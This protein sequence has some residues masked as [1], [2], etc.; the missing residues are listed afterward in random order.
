MGEAALVLDQSTRWKAAEMVGQSVG[1]TDAGYFDLECVIEK[2]TAMLEIDQLVASGRQHGQAI[3]AVAQAHRGQRGFSQANLLK[4]WLLWRNGGQKRDV[5][6]QLKGPHYTARDWRIFVPNW[7]NGDAQSALKNSAFVNH[8][9]RLHAETTR[10]DATGNALHNRLL[11]DWFAGKEI[12]GYGTI[13]TWCAE[14]GRPI[15][16]GHVVRRSTNYPAGWSVDN[17]LRMLPKSRAKRALVQRGEHAAH[18]HWG[19][20][21]LR[22]RSKLMPFQLVTFD[23]LRFDIRVIM[24][25]GNGTAQVVYPWAI[26]ALDVATGMI[27]AKGV[28]GHYTRDTDSDGG[29]AGTKRGIQQSDT[30]FLLHS[31]LERFGLPVDWQMGLLLENAS[32]SIGSEDELLFTSLTG[33]RFDKT[34]MVRQQLLKSG[35][36]DEGGMPWQKGWIEA[37]FRGLHCRIN[38]L[39]GTVGRRY[40]LTRG[41]QADMEAYALRVFRSALDQ[42]LPTN[43]LQLPILTLDQFHSVLDDYVLRLNW[44]IAH[45]LQGFC[46]VFEMEVQPG[47]FIRHDDPRAHQIL[48]TGAQLTS[49]LEAPAERFQRLMQGHRMQ[50]VHP[51]ILVPLAA[52]KRPVTVRNERVEVLVS[53]VSTD[54]LIFRDQESAAALAEWN[55]AKK[56]LLGILAA[57][58]TCIHLFTND[59][60]LRYVASPR[61][62]ARVDLTDDH[63]ILARAGEVHRGRQQIRDEVAELLAPKEAQYAEMRAH[64]DQLLGK[65]QQSDNQEVSDSQSS[66]NKRDIATIR[67]AGSN[68]AVADQIAPRLTDQIASA[69]A[70]QR[71]DKAKARSLAKHRQTAAA[72][73]IGPSA[74]PEPTILPTRRTDLL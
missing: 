39:P 64:N 10:E 37:L 63:A 30:R 56:G 15:P 72:D 2:V 52:D 31:L 21:L 17:L 9:Q 18:D 61:N 54:P 34:G 59:G 28:V 71:A 38:H 25:M 48:A 4:D 68:P 73:L 23:D 3:T 70:R 5:Q 50:P 11:D 40:D 69:E 58:H 35:F 12:P 46:K 47:L 24:D 42:G 55:G 43:L 60:E 13:F 65:N 27:L 53:S 41:T 1:G 19:D 6:G 32:A 66:E 74:R 51:R 26:F 29:K 36:R 7:T 16:A 8:V 20:Q 44:R 62:V 67:P 22:D 14:Q 57:D 33:V 49:R 45:K